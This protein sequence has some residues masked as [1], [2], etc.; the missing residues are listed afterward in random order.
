MCS[1]KP[2][3][4]TRA[5]CSVK[6][7]TCVV[8]ILF[9]TNQRTSPLIIL[10]K[11][12]PHVPEGACHTDMF[13]SM[14]SMLTGFCNT[15]TRIHH[16]GFVSIT[17][18]PVSTAPLL[19]GETASF[20]CEAESRP[21]PTI[22]WFRVRGGSTE[23]LLGSEPTVEITAAMATEDTTTSELA[24]IVEGIEEQ[25]FCVADNGFDNETSDTVDLIL[26][27]TCTCM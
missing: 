23:M 6:L 8:G 13:L 25:F 18:Q 12:C 14:C 3:S 16:T 11:L 9:G 22:T 10:H 17:R 24:V 1:Y 20:F 27:G 15:T 19:V 7:S 2:N 21:A 5:A 26:A 4:Q